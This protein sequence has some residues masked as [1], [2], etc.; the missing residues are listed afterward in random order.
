MTDLNDWAVSASIEG[1]IQVSKV[2][3]EAPPA[4]LRYFES[5]FTIV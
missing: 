5:P 1:S 4:I 2:F 3:Y